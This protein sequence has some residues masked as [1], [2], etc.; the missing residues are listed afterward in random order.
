VRKKKKITFWAHD[1]WGSEM[2]EVRLGIN[3][4]HSVMI[5]NTASLLIN[6]CGG[7]SSKGKQQ[8]SSLRQHEQEGV[9]FSR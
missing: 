1:R 6:P 2:R 9:F 7:T 3:V 4:G 8:S 5:N